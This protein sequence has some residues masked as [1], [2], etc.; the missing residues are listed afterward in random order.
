[1]RWCIRAGLM[2]VA[3]V[4]GASSERALADI[5][6]AFTISDTTG[7]AH[8]D[9]EFTI[10]WSFHTNVQVTV[11]SLGVF[12]DKQDG[13]IASHQVAIFDGATSVAQVTVASGKTDPLTNQFR[14]HTLDKQVTLAADKDY[15]IGA[16]FT[17]NSGAD[18]D[19]RVTNAKDFKIIDQLKYGKALYH[20]GD[21]LA[22]PDTETAA[23]PGYFGPNFTVVPEP[24]SL[25]L[26]GIAALGLGGSV[27]RRRKQRGL[28]TT[29]TRRDDTNGHAGLQRD[30]SH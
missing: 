9:G 27:W 21:T 22:A 8:I 3:L 24:S 12:D 30:A 29:E 18:D 28:R 11:Y 5:V 4:L 17:I 15:T 25:S 1:M 20:F 13:L 26:L 23:D 2:A 6:P 10:G 14:Y 16:L 7:E 19:F